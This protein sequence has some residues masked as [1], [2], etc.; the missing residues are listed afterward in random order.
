MPTR[1][2]AVEWEIAT[3]ERFTDVVKRGTEAA[4]RGR[5]AFRPRRRQGPRGRHAGTGTASAPAREISPVG[6][7]RTAPKQ[8]ASASAP[9]VRVRLVP[10]LAG[11]LLD[12]L[13]APGRGGPRPRR[14]PRRLH[15]RVGRRHA[16]RCASTTATS[17][18]T[19]SGYRNRY[20]LYKSDP[21]LLN[22]PTPASRGSSPG[23]TT[24]SRTTTPTRTTTGELAPEQ[25]LARRAAAYKAYW[26]HQPLRV[27]RR[28]ARTS[29][30]TAAS[31][32]ATSL[33]SRCSTAVSTA[34]PRPC[35]ETVV[36]SD[37]GPPCPEASDPA[38]SMI[39]A[40]AGG[41][42]ARGAR[43]SRRPR[44]NVIAQQTV[45]AKFDVLAGPGE[46]YNFD[47]W[48]GY[49]ASRQRILDFL[50]EEQAVQPGGD[51]GRHPRL[52]APATS[53]STST[54]PPRPRSAPSSSAPRSARPSPRASS[55][56]SRRRCAK[57]PTPSTSRVGGAGTCAARST[58]AAGA[59]TT[60][61]SR[62]TLEQEATIETGAS[63]VVSDGSNTVE[64]A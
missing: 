43:A 5:R 19:S 9:R 54:T 51:H 14:V 47:Q 23:T 48:D 20:G 6:R 31:S 36:M 38:R 52:P 59:A 15:V 28:R 37:I 56:S 3:D 62:R 25:F 24:R 45:F 27:R 57:R 60:A 17:R 34:R 55:R 44:W 39:G 41:V 21:N 32:S 30:S 16:A 50:G 29:A 63:F 12:P 4:T 49:V 26:E 18:W 11:R 22:A 40:R 35:G 42:A 61:T 53:S 58:R 46:L 64:R 2:V 33:S 13:R 10:A 1:D 7:T 8:N